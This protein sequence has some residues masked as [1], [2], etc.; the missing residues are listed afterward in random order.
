MVALDYLVAR[1]DSI[2]SKL[3]CHIGIILT[4]KYFE[5]QSKRVVPAGVYG[6]TRELRHAFSQGSLNPRIHVGKVTMVKRR[7]LKHQ[8]IS[9]HMPAKELLRTEAGKE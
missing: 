9:N 1:D 8:L 4:Q 7:R 5:K 3:P 6:T 2:G